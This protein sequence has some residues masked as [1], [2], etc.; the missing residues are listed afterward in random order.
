MLI[1][2]CVLLIP[3]TYFTH[4]NH[5]YFVLF[6]FMFIYLLRGGRE[7]GEQ[8]SQSGSVLQCGSR[9]H[10]PW[11]HDLSWN[12][13][14]WNQQTLNQLSH[15]G[16]PNHFILDW[17][18]LLCITWFA[19]YTITCGILYLEPNWFSQGLNIFFF[20]FQLFYFSSSCIFQNWWIKS[21]FFFSLQRGLELFM[22]IRILKSY[23]RN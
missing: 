3:F 13:P 7:I 10:K 4:T 14:S 11:Y 8:E 20:V 15:S 23:K 19:S 18:N 9:T 2:I 22:P 17:K 6:Y 5:F 21:F 16:T 12:E 1:K